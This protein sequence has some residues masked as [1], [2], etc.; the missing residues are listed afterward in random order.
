MGIIASVAAREL[1]ISS[2]T[3]SCWA[4]KGK[5]KAT[6]LAGGWRLYEPA[7]IARLKREM[8]KQHT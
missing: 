1:G 2:R 4:I 5:I 6:R 3:L 7:D 8:E